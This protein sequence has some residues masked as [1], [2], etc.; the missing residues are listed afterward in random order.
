MYIFDLMN[1]DIK[2]LIQLCISETLSYHTCLDVVNKALLS[3]KQKEVLGI[4]QKAKQNISSVEIPKFPI[5]PTNI[6]FPIFQ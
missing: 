1:I 4:F 3:S 5:L 2:Y 6:L